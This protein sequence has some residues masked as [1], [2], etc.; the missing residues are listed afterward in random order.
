MSPSLRFV[1]WY[2][3]RIVIYSAIMWLLNTIFLFDAGNETVTGKF[4]EL[5]MTE[6]VQEVF[7][8]ILGVL[9]IFIGRLER[10]LKPVSVII[11]LFFFIAL[12][13][14]L[15]NMIDFWFYITVPLLAWFFWQIFY[16][17]KKVIES[18]RK[19]LELHFSAYF[20]SGFL[21]SF[22]F[23]RLF[24]RTEMWKELLGEDYNRWAKNAAEE[25][26]ELLGYTLLLI[27]GIEI[28][29]AIVRRRNSKA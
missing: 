21:V 20:V 17:F 15:N 13:R 18:L 28:F 9:F 11:S 5:S 4:G 19:F 29:L 23:S 10:D 7:L 22:I 26:V 27:A 3:V 2:A 14:E 24:G 1:M 8:L 25:G 6:I 16:H 12:I